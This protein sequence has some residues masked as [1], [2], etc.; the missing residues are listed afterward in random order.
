MALNMQALEISWKVF[1][2]VAVVLTTIASSTESACNT[3]GVQEHD[4]L[5]FVV[6]P[7][8]NVVCGGL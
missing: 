7:Q 3:S 8:I 1:H 6:V 4:T 2:I 5:F